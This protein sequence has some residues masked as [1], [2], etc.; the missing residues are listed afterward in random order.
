MRA[1]ITARCY[2]L[3]LRTLMVMKMLLRRFALL[4]FSL[5]ISSL[6]ELF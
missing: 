4:P 3:I 1:A 5:C 6:L 2:A